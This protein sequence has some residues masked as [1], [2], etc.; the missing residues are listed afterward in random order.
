[1]TNIVNVTLDTNAE[2]PVLLLDGSTAFF[3]DPL[4]RFIVWKLHGNLARASFM[5]MGNAQPGFA[6]N[7]PPGQMPSSDIFGKPMVGLK[8]KLL[9]MRNYHPDSSS[10]GQ[11]NY[12]LWV[13]FN[14]D[15]YTTSNSPMLATTGPIII[16]HDQ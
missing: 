14:G 15:L 13:S 16:N 12:V 4:P 10:H 5:P 2:Q 9:W 8:E 6:W 7:C 1:M 11:W 3:Y